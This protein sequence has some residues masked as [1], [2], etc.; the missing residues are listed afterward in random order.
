V[1]SPKLFRLLFAATVVAGV[2]AP[3]LGAYAAPRKSSVDAYN[4]PKGFFLLGAEP[5]N[6]LEINPNDTVGWIIKEG[7]HTVTPK[8]RNQWGDGGS[9]TL[10]PD[11]PQYVADHF[12]AP[13]DY[14]Y[15]CSIHSS[16]DDVGKQGVGMWGLVHVKDPN[17]PVTQPPTT[18]P[19]TTQPPTTQ[20]PATTSTTRQL[21]ST[22]PAT[23]ATAPTTRPSPTTAAP[24]TT[25]KADK[26]KK[27]KDETSTTTVPSLTPPP[28]PIDLPD[29]AIIPA[30]P[31]ANTT[32]SAEP[33][34]P[35]D[36]PEG[37]AVA[38]LKGKKD[39]GGDAMKLLIVSGIGLGALGMGTAGYK[40]A[41][42]S[43]KYFPA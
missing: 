7:E 43:S 38:L 5:S 11:S 27:P 1:S 22:P 40:Y 29:E 19:P 2:S 3:M 12:K 15:Y 24:T 32:S 16:P 4:P 6:T 18:Q 28:P 31:S 10:K 41:N 34:A 30:L 36:T 33:G 13:G 39:G 17:P 37:E 23:T 25:T 35:T 20:P 8:D 9:E 21:G 14:F 26:D 42:R